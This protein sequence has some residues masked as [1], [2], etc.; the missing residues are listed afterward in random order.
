[1]LTRIVFVLPAVLVYLPCESAE[2]D[3]IPDLKE[4]GHRELLADS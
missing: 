3:E 4:A 2:V 1:M